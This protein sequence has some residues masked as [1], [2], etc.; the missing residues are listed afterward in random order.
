MSHENPF[1]GATQRNCDRNSPSSMSRTLLLG[2]S[3]R[4]EWSFCPG[5]GVETPTS[6]PLPPLN[7]KCRLILPRISGSWLSKRC[8]NYSWAHTID[9]LL[10]GAHVPF[11]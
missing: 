6:F 1:V 11:H 2:V 3:G 7:Q 5:I 8:V 9:C 4:T 10:K